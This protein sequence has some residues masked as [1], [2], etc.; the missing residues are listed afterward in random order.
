MDCVRLVK[1]QLPK[2]T[3]IIQTV[4]N[5]LSQAKNLVG[6]NNLVTHM[7]LYPDLVK[8]ALRVI[9]DTTINFLTALN[10]LGIDGIFY[11]VQHAQAGLLSKAEFEEF[12]L[13]YDLEILDLCRQYW[14]N[15]LHIHGENIYFDK[16]SKYPCHVFNWHDQETSPDLTTAKLQVSGAVCGGFRQWESLVNGTP[17]D[18]TRE[19]KKAISTTHGES[20]ILGTG[21]VLPITAPLQISL[22]LERLLKWLTQ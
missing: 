7:R 5:P 19:A 17:E 6:K 3:P 18:I 15:M 21:C 1:T 20:F 16:I 4:F 12:S 8:N 13:P 22:Q 2:N 14:L 9:T 11:A 10:P